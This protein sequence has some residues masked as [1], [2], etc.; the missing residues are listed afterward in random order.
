MARRRSSASSASNSRALAKGAT[1]TAVRWA[2]LTATASGGLATLT[3][4]APARKAARAES[5]AAPVWW[6]EPERTRTAPRAYLW[7]AAFGRGSASPQTAGALTKV[8]GA[9]GPSAASGMPMSASRI[10]PARARPGSRRWPGFSRKKVTLALASTASPTNPA[11][12]PIDSGGN[13]DREHAAAC[14]AEG[15]DPLDDRL[16]FAIDVAREPRAEQSV[17]HAVGFS[18]VNCRGGEDQALIASGGE[19]GIAFQGVST[20]E[21]AEFDRVAALAEQAAGDEAV[22][23]VASRATKHNDPAA[24]LREP[25]RFV[26]DRKPRPL[27]ELNAG[28]PGRNRKAVGPVHFSWRQEFRKR[29]GIAH[30]GEG[31]RRSRS[32]QGGQKRPSHRAVFCYIAPHADPR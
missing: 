29:H 23:T 8:F 32:A 15:V 5:R 21:Q 6:P 7:L 14:M 25:R 16:R 9:M 20:A 2:E 19:R 18:E 12:F 3:M 24:R 13:V 10:A 17:D 26:S 28:R 27:H 30:G 4:P 1:I 31:A 22:P 11:G